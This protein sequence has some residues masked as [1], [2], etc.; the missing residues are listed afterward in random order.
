M[1]SQG[2]DWM[3]PL[4]PSPTCLF[5]LETALAPVTFWYR[6]DRMDGVRQ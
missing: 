4:T 2:T 3:L 5:S 1:G 6:V